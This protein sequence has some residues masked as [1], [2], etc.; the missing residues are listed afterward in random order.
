[1][2]EKEEEK[3]EEVEEEDKQEEEDPM[4]IASEVIASLPHSPP[5]YAIS[6]MELASTSIIMST[7]TIFATQSSLATSQLQ[8]TSMEVSNT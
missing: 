5:K 4:R 8:V 7:S 3:E 1:M 6:I 2:K